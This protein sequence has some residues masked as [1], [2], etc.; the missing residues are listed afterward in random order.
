ML[1]TYSWTNLLLVAKHLKGLFHTFS[2][3]K[4]HFESALR[5]L[6]FDVAIWHAFG[7]SLRNGADRVETLRPISRS[8]PTGNHLGFVILL[9]CQVFEHA[10]VRTVHVTV[11]VQLPLSLQLCN[12]HHSYISKTSNF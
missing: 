3:L 1:V 7:L 8:N 2:I 4:L 5:I 11:V 10:I 9:R 6:N 12:V